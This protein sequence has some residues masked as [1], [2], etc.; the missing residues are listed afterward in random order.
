MKRLTVFESE[1]GTA[2]IEILPDGDSGF[3]YD[4]DSWDEAIEA[5]PNLEE[6]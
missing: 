5:L 2:T 4:F 3:S 6:I 1:D